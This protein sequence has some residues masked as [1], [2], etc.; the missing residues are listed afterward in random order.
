MN[1]DEQS[2]TNNLN[3]LSVEDCDGKI[4]RKISSESI[5]NTSE[6]KVLV[7]YTGGTI[8][9]IRNNKNGKF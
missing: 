3:M 7:L 6:T 1:F 4:K 9:M 8:G 5:E 2:K